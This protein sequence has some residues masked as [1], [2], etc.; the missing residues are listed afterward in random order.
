MDLADQCDL[1]NEV[2]FA[3]DLLT[4]RKPEGPKANGAC[5]F[6]KEPLSEGL[7]FCDSDCASDFERFNRGP[8]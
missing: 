3:F 2:A 1:Q 5:H 4:S 6:C 8:R 7:R